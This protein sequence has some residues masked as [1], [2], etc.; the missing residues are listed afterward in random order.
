MF[1][2]KVNQ[3][4]LCIIHAI[5][6]SEIY[7]INNIFKQ[8]NLNRSFLIFIFLTASTEDHLNG[9][10]P[11]CKSMEDDLYGSRPQ[12]RKKSLEDDLKGRRHQ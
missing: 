1:L 4:H 11:Q 10:Q 6:A 3:L 12:W 8:T 7:I 2:W 9:R 5:T